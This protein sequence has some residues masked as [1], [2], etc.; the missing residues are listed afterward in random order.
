MIYKIQFRRAK[1]KRYSPENIVKDSSVRDGEKL[2]GNK[3]KALL[4]FFGLK[5]ERYWYRPKQEKKIQ[6]MLNWYPLFQLF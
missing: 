2:S 6:C 3:Q 1:R 5:Y 4:F